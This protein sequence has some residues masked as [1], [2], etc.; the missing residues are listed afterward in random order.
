MARCIGMHRQTVMEWVPIAEAARTLGVSIDTVR[1]RIRART[2]TTRRDERGRHFIAAES[3][4]TA[5]TPTRRQPLPRH[6]Y[7]PEAPE[8]VIAYAEAPAQLG[9][10]DAER[11][12]LRLDQANEII[13]KGE[14]ERSELLATIT[15]ERKAAD[16]FRVLL[17]RT[18][19]TMARLVPAL[20]MAVAAPTMT[21]TPPDS[22][23]T[24]DTPVD[25]KA[26]LK[27]A[28]VKGR[29]QRRRW[30]ERLAAVFGRS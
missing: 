3:L 8:H 4:T 18:Q 21:A 27:E 10:A 19:E 17:L 15:A 6:A 14:R 30:A 5:E 2:L 11:L 26:L 29:K 23:E 22:G 12:Q 7:A 24:P 1:R 20:P 25:L 28:G 9:L 13:A 16:E